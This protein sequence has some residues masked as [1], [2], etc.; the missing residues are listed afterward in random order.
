MLASGN[1]DDGVF[2]T[3][4]NATSYKYLDVKAQT[5]NVLLQQLSY[6]G[7]VPEPGTLSVVGLGAVLIGLLRRKLHQS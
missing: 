6:T 4:T 3:V 1:N 7:S 2:V 5:N